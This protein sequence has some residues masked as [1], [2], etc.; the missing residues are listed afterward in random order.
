MARTLTNP[1]SGCGATALIEVGG[2]TVACTGKRSVTVVQFPSC[3]PP[4]PEPPKSSAKHHDVGLIDVHGRAVGRETF[5]TRAAAT[6]SMVTCS[7]LCAVSSKPLLA[8]R[9][10]KM[11]ASNTSSPFL[12]V[13][14]A[15]VNARLRGRFRIKARS[16]FCA[17]PVKTPIV[18]PPRRA[19]G[20]VEAA[21]GFERPVGVVLHELNLRRVVTGQPAARQRIGRAG[22]GVGVRRIIGRVGRDASRR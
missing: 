10:A 7:T 17:G 11:R 19:H 5:R 8:V 20:H 2:A 14:R 1:D 4:K 21:T 18:G 15:A 9:R 3:A 13:I 6:V 12:I 16:E 22:I